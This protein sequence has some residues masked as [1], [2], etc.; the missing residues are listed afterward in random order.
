MLNIRAQCGNSRICMSHEGWATGRA[1]RSTT[2][3]RTT[4]VTGLSDNSSYVRP[5][6]PISSASSR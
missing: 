1:A 4:R 6:A 3:R 5:Y 2:V